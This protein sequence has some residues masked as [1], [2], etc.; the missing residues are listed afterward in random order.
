MAAA[1][2]ATAAQT[3][4]GLVVTLACPAEQQQPHLLDPAKTTQ[5]MDSQSHGPNAP[6]F[7]TQWHACTV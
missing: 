6:L 7:L 4:A 2:A 1:A 5:D 3:A